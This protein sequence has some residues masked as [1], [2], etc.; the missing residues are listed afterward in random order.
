MSKIKNPHLWSLIKVLFIKNVIS[1]CWAWVR[2]W[3]KREIFLKSPFLISHLLSPS[4]SDPSLLSSPLHLPSGTSPARV[5]AD[6]LSSTGADCLFLNPH[7]CSP[8]QSRLL[9][10]VVAATDLLHPRHLLLSADAAVTADCPL[11]QWR[12]LFS[13]SAATNS[14]PR[15]HRLLLSWQARSRREHGGKRIHRRDHEGYPLNDG[16][17]LCVFFYLWFCWFWSSLCIL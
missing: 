7:P 9:L 5:A 1:W 12:L 3:E 17:F 10:S 8:P 16:G 14:P 6:D 15:L 4:L 11:R 13:T 2:P